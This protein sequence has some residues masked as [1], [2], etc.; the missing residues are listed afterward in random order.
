MAKA[1]SSKKSEAL[2]AIRFGMV[3]LCDY[4]TKG[5]NNK[6]T[7]VNIYGGDVLVGAFPAPLHFGFY[8]EILPDP[9][10]PEQ[11][12]LHI[13]IEGNRFGTVTIKFPATSPNRPAVLLIPA[14]GFEIQKESTIEFVAEA[15]GYQPALLMSKRV[16]QTE[17]LNLE[18]SASRQ[19][20]SRSRS[21]SAR[22]GS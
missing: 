7:L 1:K 20:S 18:T 9:G 17:T 15:A 19:P 21:A 13:M 10:F 5:E 14:L 8:A 4:A 12:D 3:A 6:H 16:L 2:K 11:V 22:K